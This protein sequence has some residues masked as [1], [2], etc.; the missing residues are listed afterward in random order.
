VT[1][2]G[3]LAAATDLTHERTQRVRHMARAEAVRRRADR[4]AA[5][6]ESDR[7]RAAHERTRAEQLAARIAA[8]PPAPWYWRPLPLER[9]VRTARSRLRRG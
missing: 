2:H 1:E 9:L 6:A 8:S 4:L 5:R 3:P 7:R